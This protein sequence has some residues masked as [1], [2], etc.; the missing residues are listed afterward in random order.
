MKR[1]FFMTGTDTEVGK[2]Y[3]S[4]LILRSLNDQSLRTVGLKPIAAGACDIDGELKN[5]DAITLQTTASIKLPYYEVNPFC[6]KEAVAPHIAAGHEGRNLSIKKVS[7][8]ISMVVEKTDYDVCLIE[9]AGGWYV[10]L[11]DK[12]FLSDLVVHNK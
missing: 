8:Q 2:T 4:A 10:P 5:E 11:N 3:V 1:N 9:G 12:E 6:Y 7:H